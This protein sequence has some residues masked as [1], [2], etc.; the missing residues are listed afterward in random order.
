MKDSKYWRNKEISLCREQIET[1]KHVWEECETLRAERS[2]NDIVS[3][4]LRDERERKNQLKI[5]DRRQMRREKRKKLRDWKERERKRK[6]EGVE[7][8]VFEIQMWIRRQ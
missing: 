8:R 6:S 3:V 5:E 2:W 1:W 7:E 4:V